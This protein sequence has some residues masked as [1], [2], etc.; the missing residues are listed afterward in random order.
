[1]SSEK[2]TKY[3]RKVLLVNG[4]G[5]FVIAIML[6]FFTSQ[7]AALLDFS[8]TD[9]MIYLS[10]GWGIAALSFGL[11]RFFASRHPNDDVCW[12]TAWFGLFEGSVLTTFGIIIVASTSL[13][14]AQVALSTFFALFFVVTYAIAFVLKKRA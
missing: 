9:E 2:A 14:L 10:G 4:I 13:T 5:D 11:L 7:M 3:L 8:G 6:M 12:F 1:M